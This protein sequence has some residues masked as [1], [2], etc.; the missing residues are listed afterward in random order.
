MG[1]Q[2]DGLASVGTDPGRC[3]EGPGAPRHPVPDGG[4]WIER[5]GI[6]LVQV[7]GLR[8]FPCSSGGPDI[9]DEVLFECTVHPSP[10][11]ESKEE[12]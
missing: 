5:I 2:T 6:V 11:L 8:T 3:R 10:R 1:M 7:W 12:A 9:G 4:A